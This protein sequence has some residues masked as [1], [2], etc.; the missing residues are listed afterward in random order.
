MPDSSN[1][2]TLVQ[3]LQSRS[4]RMDKSNSDHIRNRSRKEGIEKLKYWRNYEIGNTA[5]LCLSGF[6]SNLAELIGSD[7]SS[8]TLVSGL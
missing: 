2:W 6:L 1:F 4:M 8:L 7:G 5:N 3:N